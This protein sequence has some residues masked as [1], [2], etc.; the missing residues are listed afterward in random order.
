MPFLQ[1]LNID[2][3]AFF[4]EASLH[5]A[6][7][8]PTTIIDEICPLGSGNRLQMIGSIKFVNVDIR[9]TGVRH[10]VLYIH[11]TE[12]VLDPHTGTKFFQRNLRVLSLQTQL[13]RQPFTR[14]RQQFAA[15]NIQY[16][17]WYSNFKQ[18]AD[19]LPKRCTGRP[20]NCQLGTGCH[21]HKCN[22]STDQ[23]RHRKKFVD[24]AGNDQQHEQQ[25]IA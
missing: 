16:H 21:L 4:V 14:R 17:Q 11:E 18:C 2:A 13:L 1:R 5:Y 9:Q 7:K 19:Q 6:F 20:D 3:R 25:H 24:M 23:H 10:H 8:L 12:F 22:N 15:N